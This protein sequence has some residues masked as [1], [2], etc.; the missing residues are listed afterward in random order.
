MAW[1]FR[2]TGEAQMV[3]AR[4][5]LTYKGPAVE[6]GQMDVYRAATNMVAFS[7]FVTLAAKA[8]YGE[9]IE[10]TASV[11]GFGRGSFVTD[12]A[13]HVVGAT[14]SIFSNITPGQLLA[15]LKDSIALWKHLKGSP[16]ANVIRNGHEA[17][18]TNKDG[19]VILVQANTVNLV[20]TDKGAEAV[21]QFIRDALE[22]EG[23]DSVSLSAENK[24]IAT[25]K[26]SERNYFVPVSP[27]ETTADATVKM[28]LIVEAPVFKDGNKWRFSDG[29]SS[30]YADIEDVEFLQNVNAGEPFAKGDVIYAEVRIVQQKSGMKLSAERTIIKVFSH[31]HA[32]KQLGTFE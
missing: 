28:G 12:I 25:V 4:I 27:S 30:F 11:A 1:G 9:R 31:E 32:A 8:T 20:L 10:T 13:F 17:T 2:K 22:P 5:A 18:V 15:V 7:E 24:A 21:G 26:Q 6:S 29:Q 14:A 3:E 19:K 16:P 23:M